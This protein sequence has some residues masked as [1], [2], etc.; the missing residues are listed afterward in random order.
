MFR[1]SGRRVHAAHWGYDGSLPVPRSGKRLSRGNSFVVAAVVVD[2]PFLDRPVALPVLTRLWRK[3]GPTK[4]TLARHLIEIIAAAAGERVV[5]VVADAAYICTEL[6]RLPD[7]VT[8]TGPLPRKASLWQ[9]HPDLDDPPRMRGRGRPRVAGDRIGTPAQ[10]A[11]VT[12]G[13]AV[14]VTR[15]GRTT[16]VT[17]H[18]QRC[19]WRGVF[20]ARPVRVLVVVEPGQPVLAL[21]TTDMTTPAAAIV[22][23]Y[24]GRWSIEVAFSDAKNNTGV[25]EARNRTRQ[26]VQRTVPFGLLTQSIVIV[27]YQ[28]AGHHPGVARERRHRAPWYTTKKY[29]SYAD[30]IGKLRRL[31]IAAQFLPEVPCQPTADEIRAVRLA[32][33]QAAA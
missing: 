32:W 7:Q 23:R 27:W 4:T 10:L 26:A 9:V 30:M 2:L 11:A 6:R 14:T 28:L 17:M 29:P 19:L 8:L 20:G 31:L 18:E 22:E 15:Y 25:G 24:A 3:G 13:R 1:R 16:T 33:A 21:V 12:P 5:H